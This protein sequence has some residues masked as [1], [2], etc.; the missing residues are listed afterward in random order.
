MSNYYKTGALDIA[1]YYSD[2]HLHTI[3][4][5]III[6]FVVKKKIKAIQHRR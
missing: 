2:S 3:L 4:Q 6:T 1:V 5:Y